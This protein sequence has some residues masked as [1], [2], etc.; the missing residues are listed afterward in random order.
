MVRSDPV[1]ARVLS[2]S[3]FTANGL[4]GMASGIR[5]LA[6]LVRCC[7]GPKKRLVVMTRKLDAPVLVSD[8]YLIC[9]DF[10]LEDRHQTMGVRVLQAAISAV[11]QAAGDGAATA[12]ILLDSIIEDGLRQI[13]Y[14]IDP[15]ILRNGIDLATRQVLQVLPRY[16]HHA[17]DD[18]CVV[19]ALLRT[20]SLDRQIPGMIEDALD[21]VGVNGVI[22]VRESRKTFSELAVAD[23]LQLDNGLVMLLLAKDTL[24]GETRLE[25]PYIF[26]TDKVIVLAHEVRV[27][28]E[29]VSALN[30]SLLIVAKNIEGEALSLLGTSHLAGTISVAAIQA[31]E[32]GDQRLETLRD[33]AALT[34]GMVYEDRLCGPIPEEFFGRADEVVVTKCST[35][36]VRP[37]SDSSQVE[38]R[39]VEVRQQSVDERLSQYDRE[40]REKRLGNLLGKTATLSIGAQN[41]VEMGELLEKVRRVLYAIRTGLKHGAVPGAGATLIRAAAEAEASLATDGKTSAG[42]SLVFKALRQPCRQLL[43]NAALDD[44]LALQIMDHYGAVD[45]NEIYDLERRCWADPYESCVVDSLQT[46]SSAIQTASSV[47]SVF[48]SANGAMSQR[49]V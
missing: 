24:N 14:G 34:G 15:A 39:I 8:T 7:Y 37:H 2:D 16:V 13:R 21:A 25:K 20:V 32:Y 27:L 29:Q 23:A 28:I 42:T 26:L 5:I 11:N 49:L 19:T 45:N 22:L 3:T 12:A 10:E 43:R 40:R 31:P 4:L 47:A 48:L 9:K 46:L 35:T 30:G 41:D 33:V 17:H 1:L 38:L 18:R 36:F 44:A 6:R